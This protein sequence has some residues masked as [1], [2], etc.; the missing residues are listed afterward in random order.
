[1]IVQ[2]PP[3]PG[4]LFITTS[5]RMSIVPAGISRFQ[6]GGNDRRWLMRL[7]RPQLGSLHQLLHASARQYD[8]S[9]E[10][11][12]FLECRRLRS[13]EHKS[14]LQSLMR[15]LY[16]VFCMKTQIHIKNTFSH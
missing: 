10:R 8:R 14:E 2:E 15:T 6:P 9:D 13:E 11:S 16:D 3:A 4:R 1:M 5:T 12:S 7:L